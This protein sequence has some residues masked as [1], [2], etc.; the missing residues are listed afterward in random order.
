[1]Y[2][3]IIIGA[4]PAGLTAGIYA[5]RKKLKTLIL[6]K[7]VG[8][9]MAWSSD[10]ENYSGFSL[11]TGAD[12]TQKFLEQAKALSED[13]EIT[14][15][16]EVVHIDKNIT[17]FVIEDKTGKI[18]YGKT[19]IIATGKK[20]RM[21]GI[22]GEKEFLGKGVALCATCDAP[23]Y[24]KKQVVVI[25]GGNS[26]LDAV[27]SLSKIAQSVTVVNSLNKLT[28][29]PSLVQKVTSLPHIKFL[30][31]TTAQKI[32]GKGVVMGVEVTGQG[33]E[34][35]ILPA[36]GVFIEIGWEPNTDFETLSQKNAKGEI[37]VDQNLQTNISGLFAAGDV[38]DA[39]GEQIVIAAGEGAKAAMA[40]ANYLR[41]L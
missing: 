21:L 15:A 22:P 13:L 29:D 30:N 16:V 10:V 2:D 1:M 11:V 28:A 32:V 26:A 33:G 41:N 23:L 3:C 20:P 25:G 34:I 38:N 27:W 6:T 12:L 4:G 19:V 39:W 37:L 18:Y 9:Q 40:M 31:N 14:E 36:A 17:S 24:K 5:A 7:E 35:Q 8:G